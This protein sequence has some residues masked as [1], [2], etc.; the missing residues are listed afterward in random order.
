ML[1]FTNDKNFKALFMLYQQLWITMW[2][3]L[4][5]SHVDKNYSNSHALKFF[6]YIAIFLLK[7]LL[8]QVISAFY[9]LSTVFLTAISFGRGLKCQ[10]FYLRSGKK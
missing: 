9:N 4:Y 10:I 2:I 3:T 7:N 8:F 6:N 1:Y 5:Y